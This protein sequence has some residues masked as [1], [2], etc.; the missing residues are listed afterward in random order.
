MPQHNNLILDHQ[1][2]LIFCFSYFASTYLI[3]PDALL[4]LLPIF[5]PAVKVIKPQLNEV[6]LPGLSIK[7]LDCKNSVLGD[8]GI[9]LHLNCI[10][11]HNKQVQF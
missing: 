11:E 10:E 4:K 5:L 7:S 9:K 8:G 3:D 6:A 2:K 1:I